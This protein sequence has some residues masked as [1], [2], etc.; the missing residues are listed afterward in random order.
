M[1]TPDAGD[2]RYPGGAQDSPGYLLWVATL[3][4]QRLV[5]GAL[6]PLGL[7]HVQFVLLASLWWLDGHGAQPNQMTLAR[8]AGTDVKMASQVL[9]TLER[10]GL[11][12]RVVDPADSRARTVRL[13]PDGP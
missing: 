2:T 6:G 4:W 9:R 7:T 3:R 11:L 13:T 10:K 1:S 8:H 12:V 5:A